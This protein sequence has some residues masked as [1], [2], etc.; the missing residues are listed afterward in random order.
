MKCFMLFEGKNQLS[1]TVEKSS[2]FSITEG[3]EQ[4]IFTA[5]FPLLGVG[6]A[7]QAKRDKS[8]VVDINHVSVIVVMASLGRRLLFRLLVSHDCT[9]SCR[10]GGS[11]SI[12]GFYTVLESR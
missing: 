4:R 3:N 9:L 2:Q 5:R 8:I 7:L 6:K 10:A 11:L 1:G 12:T